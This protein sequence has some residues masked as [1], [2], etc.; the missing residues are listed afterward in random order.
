MER[1]SSNHHQV[2][3]KKPMANE[4]RQEIGGGILAG[5]ERILGNSER[6]KGAAGRDTERDLSMMLRL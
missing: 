2:S 3:I 4:V 5:G 1:I 6:I